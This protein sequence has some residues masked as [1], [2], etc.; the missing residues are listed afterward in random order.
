MIGNKSILPTVAIW[1]CKAPDSTVPIEN[2]PGT[3]KTLFFRYS[4]S[5]KKTGRVNGSS[6][7]SPE[8]FQQHL[9]RE[10]V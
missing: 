6:R 7:F 4:D 10:T 9:L 2:N 5:E 1:A 8:A 3:V